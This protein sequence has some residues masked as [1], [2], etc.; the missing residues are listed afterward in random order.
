[1]SKTI[2]V[3]EV[4]FKNSDDQGIT[5]YTVVGKDIN[6]AI[7]RAWRRDEA[8]EDHANRFDVRVIATVDN[9][10]VDDDDLPPGPEALLVARLDA[11]EKTVADMAG[12]KAETPV[13]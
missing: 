5:L 2:S 13:K 1:M 11:L 12:V 6:E 3:Y 10:E 9:L 4:V 8:H 7:A